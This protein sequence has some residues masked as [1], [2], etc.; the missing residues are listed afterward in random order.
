MEI[1]IKNKFKELFANSAH[2]EIIRS[3]GRINL[4]GEHVDY[5]EGLVLPAAIDKFIYLGIGKR[6][7]DDIYL[8]S[9]DYE[10]VYQCSIN[11]IK[12]SEK[13]WA[14]YILGV[15][16]QFKKHGQI[17]SGF[18][19]VFSGDIPQGAGLSSSAAL[20]CATAYG[21]QHIN[22]SQFTKMELAKLA[23]VAE[24]QFVGVNCGLMDQFA[25]LFGKK[26][27][28]IQFDCQSL[29]YSYFPF[30]SSDYAF[31]LLDSKVEH[32]LASSA[33]NE[34]R[35][36]CEEGVRMIAAH[37][38]EIKSL[39]QVTREHLDLYVKKDNPLV[40]QR[41]TFVVGEIIRVKE[42]C[43]ALLGNDFKRLGQ[44]MFETHTGL[45]EAY[46]VS[47]VELDF[48]VNH[49][50]Q[51]SA[52]LGSRMMGGGFGGCTI[53]LVKKDK[54]DEV[55]TEATIAYK[56]E[57]GLELVTYKVDFVDGTSLI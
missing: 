42:A 40:F 52:V 51:N 27:H 14:N 47:C 49:V 37:D 22:G 4:L 16:D 26:D 18:N 35:Q 13:L 34:R 8:Y 43:Q 46:E 53:N 25:S 11:N 29:D 36:Q 44:L 20:E 32:S 12:Q 30:V 1:K 19:L 6:E 24:N 56:K 33:Y 10:D 31:I 50:K 55:I 3:P 5:N 2:P 39:R 9:L 17:I 41:C 57:L 28:L 23:Q 21:L 15:V 38:P 7:D 45:S 54:I 48:L